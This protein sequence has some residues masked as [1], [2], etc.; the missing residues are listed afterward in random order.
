M[1]KVR[2]PLFSMDA[3]GGVG[4]SIVFGGWKGIPWVREW[5][6]P[7]NPKTDPQVSVRTIFT[8]AVERYHTLSDEQKAAWQ[9]AIEQKGYTMSGFNYFVSEYCKSMRDGIEPSDTPPA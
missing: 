7:Q 1:A 5:F 4:S 6:K 9:T 2:G 3:R 8:Q